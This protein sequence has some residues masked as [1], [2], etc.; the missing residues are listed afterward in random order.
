MN[1]LTVLRTDQDS[2]RAFYGNIA[3]G[4]PLPFS[5]GE[6]QG[7]FEKKPGDASQPHHPE[8]ADFNENGRAIYLE[9][10]KGT[11]HIFVA[12][13]GVTQQKLVLNKGDAV[14]F[15]D[16]KNPDVTPDQELEFNYSGH[17]SVAV[18]DADTE[19]ADGATIRV[20]VVNGIVDLD[21]LDYKDGIAA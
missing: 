13:D 14:L 21:A 8:S 1:R 9:V 18:A 11:Y 20:A 15:M 12:H 10:L 7:P 6:W 19:N 2:G 3:V 16:F 17:W 5:L 4:E